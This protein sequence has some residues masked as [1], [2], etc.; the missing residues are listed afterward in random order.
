MALVGILSTQLVVDR[1]IRN[2]GVEAPY[3]E[4][5]AAAT[6]VCHG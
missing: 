5:R 1:F 4:H 2:F 6:A 3:A